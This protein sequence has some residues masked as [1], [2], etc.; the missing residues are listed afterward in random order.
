[1]DPPAS[2]IT[3]PPVTVRSLHS[4]NPRRVAR[5]IKTR[6]QRAVAIA[7]VKDRGRLRLE[8]LTTDYVLTLLARR[9]GSQT[10][11]LRV[12]KGPQSGTLYFGRDSFKVDRVAY[13]GIFLERWYRA[14]YRGA[15]VVDVGGHKGYY[16][17]FA[18]L[19]GAAD[20]RSYEP[21]S[22][23]FAMLERTASAFRAP[24]STHRLAV[25]SESGMSKL[26]VSA[27]SAG[28]SILFQ[29]EEGPR[30]TVDTQ[31]V[32]VVAMADILTD[33][34][35]AGRPVIVKIDA[36]G[37][38]CDIVL[39]TPV[40]IWRDVDRVFLEVHDFAPCSADD[41]LQ[42]LRGAG[43]EVDYHV[44]DDDAVL[45]GLERRAARM[46]PVAASS[47]RDH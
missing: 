34:A 12:G 24:W 23:N 44:T 28:H 22:Q 17:A 10:L 47:E 6:V 13:F 26:H 15:V 30:K 36:E 33:A 18:L 31:E 4:A 11:R 1:M 42:H 43:L 35:S 14:D 40:E 2:R 46:M 7:R 37:A 27:E 32:T 29:Q 39:G 41:I 16:G 8:L 45:L 38:E 3:T 20:V 21:E 9:T 5:L 19:A 25:G